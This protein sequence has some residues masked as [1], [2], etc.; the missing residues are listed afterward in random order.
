MCPG[1]WASGDAKPAGFDMCCLWDTDSAKVIWKPTGEDQSF[2]DGR[3]SPDGRQVLGI[4]RGGLRVADVETRKEVV[5]RTDEV[6]DS[7]T[8]CPDPKSTLI[9]PINPWCGS[10]ALRLRDR[11]GGR[12]VRAQTA[13][14]LRHLLAGG[15]HRPDGR[16]GLDHPPVG[17]QDG[18]AGPAV[19][20]REPSHLRHLLA[21]SRTILTAGADRIARLWDV[22]GGTELC[23][24]TDSFDGSWVVTDPEGRFDTNSL[25]EIRGLHGCSRTTRS[26]LSRRKRSCATTMSRGCCHGCSTRPSGRGCRHPPPSRT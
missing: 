12:A 26:C 10:L 7:A 9:V 25:E 6:G 8:F 20:S 24:L 4:L 15:P 14:L 19:R 23:Q 1:V 3:L 21:G 11:T 17:P 18:A 22:A 16:Y 13:G 2:V 5:F